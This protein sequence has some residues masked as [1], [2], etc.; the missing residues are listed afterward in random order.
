MNETATI[1]APMVIIWH[2]VT[3]FDIDALYNVSY[4]AFFCYPMPYPAPMTA[5]SDTAYT[6]LYITNFLK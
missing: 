3:R 5:L 1:A 4:C 6:L 2:T